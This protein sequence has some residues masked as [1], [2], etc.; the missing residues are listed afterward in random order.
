MKADICVHFG[1]LAVSIS[2]NSEHSAPL[3]VYPF[4]AKPCRQSQNSA[5]AMH[6]R[7]TG[8]SAKPQTPSLNPL[9]GTVAW[10]GSEGEAVVSAFLLQNASQIATWPADMLCSIIL[11]LL[12][13]IVYCYVVIFLYIILY[14]SML[15]CT[16]AYFSIVYSMRKFSKH[17]V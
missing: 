8:S 17:V 7:H 12:C 11:F 4:V 6:S 16:T 15:Q 13:Y 3:Q 1:L 14:C 5:L 2:S 9:R 10:S